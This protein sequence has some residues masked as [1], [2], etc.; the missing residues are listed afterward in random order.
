MGN[1]RTDMDRLVTN[2]LLGDS[3]GDSIDDDSIDPDATVLERPLGARHFDSFE[4][5]VTTLDRRV[6]LAEGS[7]GGAPR[8]AEL[9][10][11]IDL[12]T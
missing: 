4:S 1:S 12:D 11:G 10:A 6:E 3:L 5:G 8:D 7:S 9:P 2:D